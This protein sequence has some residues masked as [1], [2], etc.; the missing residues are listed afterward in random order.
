[1]YNSLQIL[2]LISFIIHYRCPKKGHFEEMNIMTQK[3]SLLNVHSPQIEFFNFNLLQ[4]KN[5]N[6]VHMKLELVW[7]F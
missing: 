6:N 4:K 3:V 1:M 2:N 5:I 7:C